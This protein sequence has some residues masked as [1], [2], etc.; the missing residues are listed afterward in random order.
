MKSFRFNNFSVFASRGTVH[1]DTGSKPDFVGTISHYIYFCSRESTSLAFFDLLQSPSVQENGSTES[2]CVEGVFSES[3]GKIRSICTVARPNEEPE[4]WISCDKSRLMVFAFPLDSPTVKVEGLPR[5]TCFVALSAV[6]DGSRVVS[7]DQDGVVGVW[8]TSLRALVKAVGVVQPEYGRVSIQGRF[9]AVWDTKK[10]TLFDAC[11]DQFTILWKTPLPVTNG[12]PAHIVMAGG[13]VF[14][15]D[16]DH[17]PMM[18]V[19]DAGTGVILSEKSLSSVFSR[20]A[21]AISSGSN[22]SMA[23]SVCVGPHAD[24]VWVHMGSV[25][26]VID[27]QTLDYIQ[28]PPGEGGTSLSMLV[29]TLSLRMDV[30]WGIQLENSGVTC[31]VMSTESMKLCGVPKKV[32]PAPQVCVG[33][34]TDTIVVIPENDHTSHHNTTRNTVPSPTIANGGSA[35]HKGTSSGV[36]S[37]SAEVKTVTSTRS[38]SNPNKNTTTTQPMTSGRQ[39]SPSNGSFMSGSY[40]TNINNKSITIPSNTQNAS[41]PFHATPGLREKVLKRRALEIVVCTQK[42]L[43]SKKAENSDLYKREQAPPPTVR[44]LHT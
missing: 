26:C 15:F 22:E 31:H 43:P 11:V 44:D 23:F 24:V 9:V 3:T 19:W 32:S 1:F 36:R 6:E 33:T 17:G 37:R 34:Q 38:H 5:G 10:L 42:R 39:A 40:Y 21:L 7:V 27:V 18:T 35:T 41:L 16:R 13:R 28:S 25:C 29:P 14:I 4:L 2:F 8:D 20:C 12:Q 30:I